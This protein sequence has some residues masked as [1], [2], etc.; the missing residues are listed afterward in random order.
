MVTHETVTSAQADKLNVNNHDYDI[1]YV[2]TVVTE[3]REE[4]FDKQINK[5]LFTLSTYQYLQL[6]RPRT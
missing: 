1:A 3:E 5:Y 4:I 2:I 6:Q